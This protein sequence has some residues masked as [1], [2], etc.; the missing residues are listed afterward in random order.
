MSVAARFRAWQG[1]MAAWLPSA[2][3]RPGLPGQ[4]A[5]IGLLPENLPPG[6][7]FA[8]MLKGN[9]LR[10]GQ[11]LA[12]HLP[13]SMAL[14]RSLHLPPMAPRH[15]AAA[16]ALRLRQTLPHQG[17]GLVWQTEALPREGG[18]QRHR[19]YLVKE[20][21]LAAL[22]QAAQEAGV[23][24][25]EIRLQGIGGPPLWP[26]VP[27]GPGRLL[28]GIEPR[29]RR[30]LLGT[31]FGFLGLCLALIWRLESAAAALEA[32]NA[33][34]LQ[35]IALYE[36]VLTAAAGS[37]EKVAAARQSQ[38]SD[39]ASFARSAGRLGL[40]AELSKVLADDVW[41][42]EIV[43]GEAELRLAG[44]TKGEA[45]RV[46]E[47]LQAAPWAS[48]VRLDGPVLIDPISQQNRINLWVGLAAPE[49]PKP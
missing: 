49:S 22:H 27:P 45:T 11:A 5:Q 43:I 39:L 19:I 33:A 8:R 25:H 35:R 3:F 12:V 48:A 6:E 46:V 26:P 40:L 15:A 13:L 29:L 10:A 41:L 4:A 18:Q 1:L 44:F 7:A 42:S 23:I 28:R 38:A 30:G 32:Q 21:D 20:D 37:A 34:T 24:L 9:G 14:E 47:G 36:R 31:A 16:L 17:A 2:L